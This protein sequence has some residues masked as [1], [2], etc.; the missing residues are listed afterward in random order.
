MQGFIKKIKDFFRPIYGFFV[1]V[2]YTAKVEWVKYTTNR[3][4][5]KLLKDLNGDENS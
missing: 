1:V 2:R 5:K 4:I 3:R